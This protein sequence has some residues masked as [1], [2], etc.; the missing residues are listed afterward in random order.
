MQWSREE[1]PEQLQSED[2]DLTQVQ[3]ADRVFVLQVSGPGLQVLPVRGVLQVEHGSVG[4][5]AQVD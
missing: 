1:Q 4:L 3:G 5:C 2:H